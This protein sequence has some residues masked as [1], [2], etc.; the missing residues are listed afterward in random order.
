MGDDATIHLPARAATLPSAWKSEVLARLAGAH[1]RLIRMDRAGFAEE[2]HD[3][4]EIVYVIEGRFRLGL[5][6]RVLDLDAGDFHVIPA[7]VP[8]H[9]AEG[10]HGTLLLLDT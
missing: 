1:I 6:A 9:G 7:G 2:V 8:H 5:G 3:H 10:S 4:D